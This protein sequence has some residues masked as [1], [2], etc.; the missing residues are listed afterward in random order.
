MK[1]A[2][3]FI[4]SLFPCFVGAQEKV[5]DTLFFAYDSNYINTY[6]ENPNDYYIKDG[7]GARIGG[8]Y[9]IEVQKIKNC[10]TK[11]REIS[12]KEYIRSSKFYDENRRLKLWDY[13]LSTYLKNYVIFLVKTENGK[14]SYIQVESSFEIE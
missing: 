7:S 5:K 12:L 13:D 10:K 9:F 2:T 1:I 4:L 6:P 8:F 3:L 11:K 14:K